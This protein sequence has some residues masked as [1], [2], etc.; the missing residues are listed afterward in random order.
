VFRSFSGGRRGGLYAFSAGAGSVTFQ[1]PE[2][3][4]VLVK[5]GTLMW[6]PPSGRS[7]QAAKLLLL[8]DP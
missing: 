5:E 6:N 8:N 3:G 4:S 2:R 7:S 1:L